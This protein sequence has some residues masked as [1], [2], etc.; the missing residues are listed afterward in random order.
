[1]PAFGGADLRTIFVTTAREKRSA[2]ELAAQPLAGCVL[3]F[4]VP[5]AGLPVHYARLDTEG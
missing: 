5:V 3:K 4:R 2:E 1:M